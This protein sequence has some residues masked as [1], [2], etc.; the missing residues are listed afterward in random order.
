MAAIATLAEMEDVIAGVFD[1]AG[2]AIDGRI[3]A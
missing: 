3:A 2:P 1:D